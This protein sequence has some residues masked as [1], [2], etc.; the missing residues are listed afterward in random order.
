MIQ[1]MF[2]GPMTPMPQQTTPSAAALFFAACLGFGAAWG[3]QL[4]VAVE[5]IP[6]LEVQ[7]AGYWFVYGLI[8]ATGAIGLYWFA[9]AFRV[10]IAQALMRRPKPQWQ[11]QEL[12]R[13]Y[14]LLRDSR[15]RGRE[16]AGTGGPCPSPKWKAYL[17]Q[18]ATQAT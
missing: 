11:T 2:T 5:M 12:V 13:E 10:R 15:T 8:G 16:I 6:G 14:L 18:N 7:P 9:R 17:A 4:L 1:P 3:A